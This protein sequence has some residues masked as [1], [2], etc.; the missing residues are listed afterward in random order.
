MDGRSYGGICRKTAV[1]GADDDRA[2]GCAGFPRWS[3]SMLA[4]DPLSL[5]CW[6]SS[7]SPSPSGSCYR[8]PRTLPLPAPVTSSSFGEASASDS[9]SSPLSAFSALF[10][11]AFSRIFL[12][13]RPEL[14]RRPCL[15]SPA[16][17]FTS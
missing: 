15:C 1:P 14:T 5:S 4:H 12:E 13:K 7:L 9:C 10:S 6:N 3:A 8:S 16:L 17:P 11:L 2:S